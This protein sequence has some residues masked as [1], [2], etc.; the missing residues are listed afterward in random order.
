VGSDEVIHGDLYITGDRA[1]IDGTV[2]GDVFVFAEAAD[3]SGHCLLYT[4]RCV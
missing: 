4:S 2:E 3:I 1:R